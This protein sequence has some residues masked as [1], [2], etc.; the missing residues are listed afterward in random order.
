MKLRSLLAASAALA[1]AAAS[2]QAQAYSECSG[3]IARLYVE[4]DGMVWIDFVGGGAVHIASDNPSKT[5]YYSGLLAA[6]LSDRTVTVRFWKASSTCTALNTDVQ[7][8]WVE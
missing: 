3:K 8:L 5:T 6:K 1:V 7:G 2:G 4:N